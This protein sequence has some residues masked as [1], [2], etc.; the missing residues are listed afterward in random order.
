MTISTGVQQQL[1]ARDASSERLIRI[2]LGCG[3]SGTSRQVAAASSSDETKNQPQRKPRGNMAWT[4]EEHDRF[5][6]ALELYPSGP[7]KVIA[8][9][10]G[11]R[12]PR[13]AMTHAQKY[14]QKIAR[15]Q[16]GL[17]TQSSLEQVASP[18][19][20]DGAKSDASE[21]KEVEVK[22]NMLR[23]TPEPNV[24]LSRVTLPPLKPLNSNQQPPCSLPPLRL[25]PAFQLMEFARG[26]TLAASQEN[27]FS[28]G[29]TTPTAAPR[30]QQPHEQQ[31]GY[32]SS[33]SG[34]Q[35]LWYRP[36]AM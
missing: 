9:H 3:S 10:I 8:V 25:L 5:L 24:L 36:H 28:L 15:R 33:F 26:S 16:R 22:S 31:Q 29:N 18:S 20:V 27:T 17:R 13:Q 6:E 4:D 2:P 7:W 14:R 12:T 32:P 30:P 1:F 11:T 19:S 34:P 21:S 23:K 35:Q